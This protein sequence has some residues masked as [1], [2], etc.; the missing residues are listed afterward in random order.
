MCVVR[1]NERGARSGVAT[2]EK[3]GEERGDGRETLALV[4]EP[5]ASRVVVG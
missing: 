5:Q 4:I 1:R 3:R 2:E